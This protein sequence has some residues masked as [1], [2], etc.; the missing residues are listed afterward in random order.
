MAH[1]FDKVCVKENR[2]HRHIYDTS[3]P[4]RSDRNAIG[5][6]TV[7]CVLSMF[8]GVELLC[9]LGQA[10]SFAYLCGPCFGPSF[11]TRT[12]IRI[13]KCRTIP[14]TEYYSWTGHLMQHHFLIMFMFGRAM[15]SFQFSR[16][17]REVMWEGFISEG[18]IG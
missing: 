1:Q 16:W 4:L 14:L 11:S 8:N 18:E 15:T 7:Y 9:L 6:Y 10:L 17:P 5:K 13:S 12:R 2:M 3:S